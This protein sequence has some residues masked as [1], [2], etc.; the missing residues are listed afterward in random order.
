MYIVLVLVSPRLKALTYFKS[1]NHYLLHF[2][3]IQEQ[4][5]TLPTEKLIEMIDKMGLEKEKLLSSESSGW[6]RIF[7]HFTSL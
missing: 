4:M 3:Q 7:T 2:F 5:P 6:C 1:S